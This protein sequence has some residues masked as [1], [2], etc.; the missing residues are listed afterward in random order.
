VAAYTAIDNLD[1]FYDFTAYRRL[2]EDFIKLGQ[3]ATR[4]GTAV[5]IGNR[6][7]TVNAA[8]SVMESITGLTITIKSG[9]LAPGSKYSTIIAT[10]PR[11]VTAA[12][13]EVITA[14]I[15]DGAGNSSVTIQG[16]SG[17]FT[18]WKLAN[19]T[20][21]ADY[22][23][24]TNLGNVGNTT[25][26]FLDAPGFKIVIVD[27]V[28]GYRITCPMDKGVYT[29]GLFFGSQVQLAQSAEVTQINTKVDILTNNVAAIPQEILDSTVET[30]A[31]VVE[32]LRLHNSVLG[33]KVSGG[34]SA[35]ETFRDLADTKDR[36]VSSVTETGNRTAE[37]YDLT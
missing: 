20:P 11:L 35:T 32:S 5:E 4:S 21:E 7:L 13:T 25:F 33:G 30:G 12:T 24:G 17:N 14:Q 36:L 6:N 19:A 28:T 23:T 18:L 10:P 29:R 9:V 27:N 8:A 3:I 16:G 34:G 1:K 26:R 31:T 2:S 37:V 22:A 15:E